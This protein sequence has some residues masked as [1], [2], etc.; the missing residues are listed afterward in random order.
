MIAMLSY[1]LIWPSVEGE[2]PPRH[3]AQAVLAVNAAALAVLSFKTRLADVDWLH[4]SV[5]SYAIQLAFIGRAGS[6]RP[7]GPRGGWTRLVTVSII[8]WAIAFVPYVAMYAG[9]TVEIIRA[10]LA[11][12]IVLVAAV[13]FAHRYRHVEADPWRPERWIM[14]GVVGVGGTLLA[15]APWLLL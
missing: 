11:L 10:A 6:P 1:A 4:L 15:V 2:Q 12:P 13:V 3:N 7:K 9:A 8:G 5:A 14:Q